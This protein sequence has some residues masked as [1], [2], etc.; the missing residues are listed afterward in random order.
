MTSFSLYLAAGKT[1]SEAG[2]YVL[3]VHYLFL[4]CQSAALDVTKL[5][6]NTCTG[7]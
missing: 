2:G 5:A 4:L 7:A 3:L 6:G 1:L